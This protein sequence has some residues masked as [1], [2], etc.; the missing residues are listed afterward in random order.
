[1]ALTL[2]FIEEFDDETVLIVNKIIKK[3]DHY[4]ARFSTHILG[5]S[6]SSSL[7]AQS[8]EELLM[9]L[10]YEVSSRRSRIIERGILC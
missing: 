3:P 7:T 1:M 4:E 10:G 5:I 8:K 6:Q 9:R 2:E